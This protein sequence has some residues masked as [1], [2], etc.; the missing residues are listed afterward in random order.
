MK[1]IITKAFKCEGKYYYSCNDL[2]DKEYEKFHIAEAPK[3]DLYAMFNEEFDQYVVATLAE[4]PS[5]CKQQL[6]N[7]YGN[8]W[9]DKYMDAHEI[10]RVKLIKVEKEKDE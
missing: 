10:K 1:G 9:K 5:L 6:R 4:S 7:L 2:K 8:K 3:G